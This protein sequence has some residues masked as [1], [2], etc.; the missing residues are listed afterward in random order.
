MAICTLHKNCYLPGRGFRKNR[1]DGAN[2]CRLEHIVIASHKTLTNV[3]AIWNCK[4]WMDF[5][6]LKIIAAI[7]LVQAKLYLSLSKSKYLEAFI[8]VAIFSV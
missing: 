6:E 3:N 2:S 5:P 8:D 1:V 7:K 4:K